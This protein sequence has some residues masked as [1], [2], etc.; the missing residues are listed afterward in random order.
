MAWD[1]W[2]VVVL[3]GHSHLREAESRARI[4]V[5]RLVKS[6]VLDY[7]EFNTSCTDCGTSVPASCTIPRVY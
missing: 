1:R 3:G 4:C 5:V 7:I 6:R 2:L